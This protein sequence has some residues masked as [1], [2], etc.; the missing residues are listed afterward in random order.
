MRTVGPC[1]SV[2]LALSC[3]APGYAQTRDPDLPAL[4]PPG[5][6]RVMTHDDATSTSKCVGNPVT[7]LCA[8]ETMIACFERKDGELCRIGMNVERKPF[9][10]NNEPQPRPYHFR[11]YRVLSAKR[12]DAKNPPP[13]WFTREHGQCRPD[14]VR[15]VVLEQTCWRD[16][17]RCD[18]VDSSDRFTYVVRRAADYWFVINWWTPDPRFETIRPEK[19]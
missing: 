14:D 16:P 9:F 13:Q 4:D 12:C 7:P 5:K 11:K 1:L 6:G 19:F 3:A 18:P 8:V 17:E 15:V 10:A 2:I